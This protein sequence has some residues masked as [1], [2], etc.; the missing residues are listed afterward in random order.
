MRTRGF[1]WGDCE[2]IES[3]TLGGLIV[4][5]LHGCTHLLLHC[6]YTVDIGHLV[7]NSFGVSW[8]MPGNLLQ[9]LH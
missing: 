3:P 5:E 8:A 1:K 2:T 9:F 7:L 6:A 4:K